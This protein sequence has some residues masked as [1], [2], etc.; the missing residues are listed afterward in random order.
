MSSVKAVETAA[1]SCLVF[2]AERLERE[3]VWSKTDHLLRV[4]EDKGIHSTVFVHPYSAIR[5]D[6]DI[7]MRIQ[8]ILLRGHE[9]GQHTHYYAPTTGSG[10]PE[11]DLTAANVR[12]CL[13]R[14][15]EYL[16]RSGADPRGFTAGA[17]IEHPVASGWLREAGFAYDCTGRTFGLRSSAP[18]V[19]PDAG[20]N[21]PKMG[22]G[23]VGLPTTASVTEAVRELPRRRSPTVELDARTRYELIYLHDYDLLRRSVRMAA[24][25]VVRSRTSSWRTAAELA[26][27][28]RVPS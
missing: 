11:S 3:D 10:K 20:W 2:H 1:L 26:A 8:E 25:A 9:V 19:D 13:E 16:A 5:S 12:A 17:W 14:D 22:D 7:R 6:I 27:T 18:N 15:R 24:R 21:G 4:L 23:L 28:V